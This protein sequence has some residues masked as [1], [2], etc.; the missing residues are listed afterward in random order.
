VE[1]WRARG[2][3]PDAVL[4]HSIG[5]VAAAYTAG[6]LSLPDAARVAALWARAMRDQLD[7]K[8]LMA[9]VLLTPDAMR[10]HLDRWSGR[11]ALAAVNGP[12]SV[13]VSGDA[14]AVRGLVAELRKAR[15]RAQVM[16]VAL[17]A[18]S[19]LIDTPGFHAQVHADLGEVRGRA[20]QVP[21]WSTTTGGPVD[22]TAL[23]SAHWLANL[24]GQVRFAEAV[25]GLLDAGFRAFVEISAHPVLQLGIRD[26]IEARD[27]ADAA[28]TAVTV[29][30][31]ARGKGAERTLL[32]ALAELYVNGVPVDWSGALAA[33]TGNAVVLPEPAA[34]TEDA[35]ARRPHEVWAERLS[36]LTAA[37]Q[38]RAVL[39]SV[40]AQIARVLDDA[41]QHLDPARSFKALGFESV[42]AVRLRDLL[43]KATGLRLPGA[44]VF[45]HPTPKALAAH[46]VAQ[47]TGA[48]TRTAAVE[49]RA[50]R[51]AAS[52]EPIA[53]VGMACRYPGGVAS[54]EDLWRLVADGTDA[55]GPF[56]DNRG[57]DLDALYDPDPARTG[58]TYT[59]SGGFLYDA[60]RFD[61]AF[62][63]LSPREAASMEPQ[64]RVLL[65]TAWEAFEQ[66]GIPA[67]SLPKDAVG[68]YV[69]AMTQEYGP[70]LYEAPEGL[71]GYLLT[72]NTVSVASGR[73]AYSFGFEGPALT[74][75]T[76]C[77]SSLVALHL[78]VQALRNGECDVAL[79]GGVNI[80][81]SPGVFVEFSRQR[82][83]SEDGRCKAFSASADGTGWAEGVG[84]LLVERLSDARRNGHQVLAVVRGTAI[85]QDGASNGLTAPN[86]PSQERVIRQALANAGLTPDQVDAVEAHGTG[87]R[88]GDP[89]EAQAIVNT[90]G[91]ERS[92]ERPLWLGSLKSNIGHSQAAAGVGGV[93]KM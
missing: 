33:P 81:A 72:G 39:E 17:P 65:E 47:L 34:V 59:R 23:T 51:S 49:V 92:V 19:P 4:G 40:R 53:I 45:D 91:R 28:G 38:E 26:A 2:V 78:A 61:A 22:G 77:S 80:M 29:A 83:L 66:A 86:G 30:S 76:A 14:E 44:L 52:D 64:Q 84:L 63:G 58:T 71:D 24:I 85:N 6:A 27:A 16:P 15:V 79:A 3:V 36:D 1:V 13:V 55:I 35:D 67:A 57:W 48:G 31:L 41:P 56:P 50:A 46:L 8:G 87:T 73:I 68:V 43:A 18:H 90:Y 93:I 89:I 25:D 12:G 75:D 5:D 20:A 82:G 21:L 70:R 88:L 42:T 7:G 32:A 10:P 11:V 60:D 54:P 9:S 74:V 37:E 69:G 62:F